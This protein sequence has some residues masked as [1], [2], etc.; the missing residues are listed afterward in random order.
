MQIER[1]NPHTCSF[2]D[3]PYPVY[4]HYRQH[5]PIHWGL[6]QALTD[7]GCWYLFR[8]ADVAA[9]LKDKRF[10]RKWPPGR[11]AREWPEKQRPFFE[12]ADRFLLSADPPRH[13]QLRAII[14]NAFSPNETASRRAA[15]QA[16]TDLQFNRLEDKDLVDLVKDFAMPLSLNVIRSL[17]GVPDEDE[18]D[19]AGWSAAISDGINL[20]TDAANIERARAAAVA[21]RA[22]FAT[23]LGERRKKPRDDLLTRLLDTSRGAGEF[24]E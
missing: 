7:E 21:L 12:L 15:I 24:T 8:Y 18:A 13:Q 5:D 16:M 22:Y 19:L 10:L 1:L 23:K 9:L 17:L 14:G 2:S 11:K 20:R 6:P 3:N 4:A